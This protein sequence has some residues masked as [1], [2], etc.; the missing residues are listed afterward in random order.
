MTKYYRYQEYGVSYGVVCAYRRVLSNHIKSVQEIGKTL[1]VPEDQLAEH[2][3]SKW[4]DEEFPD[5]AMQYKGYGKPLTFVYAKLHHI[6]RNP[7]HWEHWV[8]PDGYAL[9]SGAESGVLPMPE[10][11]ALEMIADWMATGQRSSRSWDVSSWL[12]KNIP[13]IRLHS[14][15]AAFVTEVLSDLGY[16]DIT[17]EYGFGSG[18]QV[19]R[20]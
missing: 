18:I 6:Q 14:K 15:T 16:T 20:G 13:L 11:Y 17:Q 9:N 5:Y 19:G 10:N 3:M 1:G 4:S 12:S 2:D 7:H 8:I